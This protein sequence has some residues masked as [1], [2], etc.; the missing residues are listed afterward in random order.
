VSTTISSI[1][2]RFARSLAPVGINFRDETFC[3]FVGR[4]VD[5]LQKFIDRHAAGIHDHQLA[6]RVA[7]HP[8]L[9]VLAHFYYK[10]SQVFR[11]VA[12][13]RIPPSW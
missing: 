8:L 1:A 12:A 10:F 9:L 4:R 7:N 11:L 13:L 3:F 2:R 5:V 6:G